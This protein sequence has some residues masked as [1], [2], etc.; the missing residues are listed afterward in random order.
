[1]HHPPRLAILKS[2]HGYF[3]KLLPALGI[4]LLTTPL[5]T[6]DAKALLLP[7]AAVQPPVTLAQVLPPDDGTRPGTNLLVISVNEAQDTLDL[8]YSFDNNRSPSV[9]SQRHQI[10]ASQN[11]QFN[12][13]LGNIL[14]STVNDGPE[15][16]SRFVSWL[17]QGQWVNL[18]ATDTPLIVKGSV[19]LSPDRLLTL[20]RYGLGGQAT[21]RGYRQDQLLTDS[22]VALS[23]EVRL[24]LWRNHGT[25]LQSTPFIEGGYGWNNQEPD[26]RDN[27][28]LA[29]GTGLL[30]RP[31]RPH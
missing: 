13:G 16:D 6:A 1:M 21:V 18:L 12:F 26:P 28:L 27:T 19:Q 17:G 15:P 11:K 30:C 5:F 10:Q 9:G 23:T 29:I 31:R 22:G 25:L 2:A 14:G 24:P 4:T 3:P 20:E 8:S 7:S